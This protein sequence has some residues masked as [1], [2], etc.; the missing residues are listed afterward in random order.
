MLNL[1]ITI[2]VCLVLMLISAIYI[3]YA[4]IEGKNS[5]ALQKDY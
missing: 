3:A 5:R 4:V 1:R 2:I